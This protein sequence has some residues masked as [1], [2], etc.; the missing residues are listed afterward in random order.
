M[1]RQQS[2]APPSAH[3]APALRPA[4]GV[5][6]EHLAR[7]SDAEGARRALRLPVSIDVRAV[8]DGLLLAFELPPGA[9]ATMVLR[10]ITRSE[11]P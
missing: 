5:T 6:P 1:A 11:G 4:T 10:E 7:S 2:A 3:S 9:Y 8:D